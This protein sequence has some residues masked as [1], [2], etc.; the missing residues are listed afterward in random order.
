MSLAAAAI[1]SRDYLYERSLA[2]LRS[3]IRE[4]V[5]GDI[6]MRQEQCLSVL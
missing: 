3:I 1:V 5:C 2:V 4:M 6:E